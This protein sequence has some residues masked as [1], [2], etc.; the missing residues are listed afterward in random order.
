MSVDWS[1]Y[2]PLPEPPKLPEWRDTPEHEAYWEEVDAITTPFQNKWGCLGV[3]LLWLLVSA[4]LCQRFVYFLHADVAGVFFEILIACTVGYCIILVP[5]VICN[6]IFYRVAK[7]KI[8]KR[9]G[10]SLKK[11]NRPDISKEIGEVLAA[12]PD[13]DKLEFSKY[14]QN[15][16]QSEIALK[17]LELSKGEWYLHKKMLYPNDPLLLF[18]YGK[19]FFLGKER[20]INDAGEFFEDI[21][22]EFYFY[23]CNEINE[24]ISFAEFVERCALAMEAA[25]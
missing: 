5:C 16:E 19:K 24:G 22:D 4:L 23:E 9:Y 1:K 2:P 6:N 11:L 17:I 3:L 18:F 25:E 13:F 8:S 21:E 15:K 14:W 7:H 12:R 10:F 20:M